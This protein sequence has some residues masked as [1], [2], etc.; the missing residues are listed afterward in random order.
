MFQVAVFLS[1]V[2]YSKQSKNEK[3]AASSS[4]KLK[5]NKLFPFQAI[6]RFVS[7]AFL[8]NI[9]KHLAYHENVAISFNL[10][11]CSHFVQPMHTYLLWLACHSH[12]LETVKTQEQ[13][14]QGSEGANYLLQRC[15]ES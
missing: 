10:C 13:K 8:K 1:E 9:P 5:T 2:F 6:N 4:Y 15:L 12:V 11:I 3:G 7:H 14:N